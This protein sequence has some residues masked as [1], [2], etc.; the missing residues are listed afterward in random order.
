MSVGS[1]RNRHQDVLEKISVREQKEGARTHHNISERK[2]QNVWWKCPR[3]DSP[4]VFYRRRVLRAKVTTLR[5]HLSPRNKPALVSLMHPV[6]GWEQ[7]HYQYTGGFQITD[8][9]A[10]G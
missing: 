9:H 8:T 10:L 4:E 3:L 5:R 1:P 2:G 7:P 6:I